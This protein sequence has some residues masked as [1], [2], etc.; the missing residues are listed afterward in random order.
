MR[1]DLYAS[2]KK[3]ARRLAV[4]Y[5]EANDV[6]IDLEMVHLIPFAAGRGQLRFDGLNLALEAK[7]F[8][9]D[10]RLEGHDIVVRA[11]YLNACERVPLAPVLAAKRAEIAARPPTQR[12]AVC[13]ALWAN[14]NGRR[15]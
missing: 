1:N 9:F 7:S 15:D 3:A 2:L 5:A 10:Y 11:P 13:A 6:L 8:F 14:W 12:D 4:K